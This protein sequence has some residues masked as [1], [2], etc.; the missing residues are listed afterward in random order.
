MKNASVRAFEAGYFVT[1]EH[2]F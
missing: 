2:E 1:V